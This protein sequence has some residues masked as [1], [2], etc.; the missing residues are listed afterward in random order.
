MV[1]VAHGQP[2][3]EAPT[4]L[5]V[6]AP[7]KKHVGDA[8]I[9]AAVAAA[10]IPFG[11]FANIKE[12]GANATADLAGHKVI[13]PGAA[14]ETLY[15]N[16]GAADSLEWV[17]NDGSSSTGVAALLS[18]KGKSASYELYKAAKLTD[19]EKAAAAK[20]APPAPAATAQTE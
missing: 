18:I 12:A 13:A 9:N 3:G 16:P 4:A 1:L 2:K 10:K 11:I 7:D 15:L 19:A 8:N 5:D 14:S 6:I 20:L 17:M